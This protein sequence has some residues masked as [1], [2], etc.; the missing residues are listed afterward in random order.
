MLVQ[1][2]LLAQSRNTS[3]ADHWVSTWTTA[4]SL[5]QGGGRA[6][7]GPRGRGTPPQTGPGQGRGNNPQGVIPPS[8]NDQ[9]IRMVARTT[10]GGRRVRV[11]FS[12]AMGASALTI[13]GAHIAVRSKES[14]IV[15]ASDRALTFAGK[16]DTTVQPGVIAFSDPVD[17]EVAPM[18]DLAVSLY[19][20]N[21]TGPPTNHPVGLHTAWISK[22]DTTGAKVMPEPETTTAY[23]WLSGVD[24][25]ADAK[26]FAIVAYG[27]SI[28]D[29]Y[30]TTRDAD[31]AW[32]TLLAKRLAG[33]KATA[34][35]AVLNQGI[36]GNQ[37]L[38]DGA[39]VSALARFE[40]D[41]LSRAGVKW[42]ILLEGIN[43]I[44]IR[45]RSTGPDAL[46]SDELIAGY[47]QLIERAHTAG[48]KVAGATIMPEEGVPTASE[49]GEE[50]RT[51]VNQW[52]RTS[53]AFDAVVDFDAMVRDPQRPVHIRADFDPG[54]HIHPNDA[55]NQA[56]ADAFDLAIF[57]K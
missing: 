28:T 50:I 26:A 19:L 30:A 6:G 33:K 38:R 40:R 13:G 43:D 20:P 9:T 7:A 4:E 52:I 2:E 35:T 56:M 5:A 29:G 46:T 17:L 42:M 22:G 25:A 8:L 49:R 10:I 11:Q 16:P 48:I 12:V 31:L 23:L 54:D 44:N 53:K 55:G 3:A 57:R 15:P 1:C 37:V 14:E 32:P 27:D 36:S 45:G 39:G 51:A 34:Q 18:S 21:D 47:R 24:V 41:V